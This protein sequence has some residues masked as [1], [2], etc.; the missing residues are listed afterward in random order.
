[1]ATPRRRLGSTPAEVQRNRILLLLPAMI[2]LRLVLSSV[3]RFAGIGVLVLVLVVHA[4]VGVRGMKNLLSRTSARA[5]RDRAWGFWPPTDSAD[6]AHGAPSD[7]YVMKAARLY[8]VAFEEGEVVISPPLDSRRDAERWARK[9]E[10]SEPVDIAHRVEHSALAGVAVRPG[11]NVQLT[12]RDA[13]YEL[14]GWFNHFDGNH[15]RQLQV[16]VT[17]IGLERESESPD[18]VV[19]GL[20]PVAAAPGILTLVHSTENK[21]VACG[22]GANMFDVPGLNNP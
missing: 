15:H 13:A 9:Y 1:M 17:S 16:L 4:A 7:V 8:C 3:D 18:E 5:E 11:R 10:H 19:F 14:D 6:Q 21:A 22:R 2:S 20:P 12:T